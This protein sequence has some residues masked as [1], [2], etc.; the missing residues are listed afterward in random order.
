MAPKVALKIHAM[1]ISKNIFKNTN[2]S[3]YVER[4]LLFLGKCNENVQLRS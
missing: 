1:G 4:Y 2:Y 3:D